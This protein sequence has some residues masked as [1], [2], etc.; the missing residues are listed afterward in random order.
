MDTV[1]LVIVHPRLRRRKK[2]GAESEVVKWIRAAVE[3]KGAAQRTHRNTLVFLVADSDELER[4]ENTTRNYLGWKMV[5]DSAEQLNLSKQQSNQADSWV[6]R[7]NDTINSNIR[8]TYMWM[9]YPEQ[10]DPTRPFELA[11]EKTSDSDGKTLTERVFT[12]IKRD[13]QLITELAPT[14]L[15][16][17][18]HS[19][20]GALWDR[21]D[22]MTVGELWGYFT[23]YAYMPRLAC[24]TVLDDALRSV[25]DV[26]LMPGEQFALATGKDSGDFGQ[27]LGARSGLGAGVAGEGTAHYQGLILPPSSAA[28]A[29]V[30]TDNTLVVKWEVAK[31]QADAEAAE[32][33]LAAQRAAAEQGSQAGGQGDQAASW[34][35][36]PAGK[37]LRRLTMVNHLLLGRDHHQTHLLVL[38]G[39]LV[40]RR[41][42]S[43]RTPTTPAPSSSTLTGTC[44]WSTTS[45]KKSST[46]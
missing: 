16:M 20:L 19:E 3:S 36:S 38:V 1:R 21:V 12:K 5:Q 37:S 39:F 26:M 45:S 28:T 22:D 44:A 34:S 42:W 23:Q 30:I 13:G 8:S 29:P 15:G 2:D 7:L 27:G 31:A 33:E 32:A 18:L 17:T 24:R 35:A 41:S 25:I 9:L 4:L 6:K 14:M 10:I 46:G 11:A 40:A 43:Y